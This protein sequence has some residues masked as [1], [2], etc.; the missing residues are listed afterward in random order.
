MRPVS[1]YVLLDEPAGDLRCE[2]GVT[3]RDCADG[4]DQLLGG[5]FLSKNPLARMD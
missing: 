4:R 2:Q 5:A 1:G 3:R